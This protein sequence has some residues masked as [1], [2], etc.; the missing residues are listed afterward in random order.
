M[1]L[2]PEKKDVLHKALDFDIKKYLM[3]NSYDSYNIFNDNEKAD[4]H[5]DISKI[6]CHI[7]FDIDLKNKYS[8]EVN[9]SW[10]AVHDY[11]TYILT[12]KMDAVIGF[13]LY[14]PLNDIDIYKERFFNII[15]NNIDEIEAI[16]KE[17]LIID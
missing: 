5:I 11:L 13:P 9:G 1:E 2:S 4:G 14:E 10:T 17:S 12:D 16:A 8:F 3:I 7:I 15:I 6:L